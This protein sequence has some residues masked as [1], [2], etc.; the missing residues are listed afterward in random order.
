MSIK[1]YL[2]TLPQFF[3]PHRLV[4]FIS[5]VLG[6]TKIKW[7]KNFLISHYI[8]K[9]HVKLERCEDTDIKDYKNF[10][11]FFI[12][13]LKKTEMGKSN[14]YEIA[15]PCEAMVRQFGN[16]K[17]NVLLQA[18]G[19][20]YSLEN[21]LL[22]DEMWVQRYMNGNYISFYLQPFNYH[23]YHMPISGTMTESI[24]V[25]A[26][27][28]FEL[29][30]TTESVIKNL[31]CDNERYIL[32]FDTKIGSV[33]VILIGALWVGGIQPIWLKEPLK[34]K[35]PTREKHTNIKLKQKDELGCFK[36]GSSIILLFEKDKITWN[37]DIHVSKRIEVLDPI[38]T[39][40]K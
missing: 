24:F 28:V 38:A 33:A 1:K 34:Y 32:F 18:K 8:K 7:L 22:Q 15:S 11:D 4:A 21:L 16:I 9:H 27:R 23:R 20:Y 19:I 26:K 13:K 29:D 6:N 17:K 5:R 36:Y 12:R 37:E 35:K 30:P 25:P 14:Q 2:K 40:K 31:Y 3:I 10:N 39:L